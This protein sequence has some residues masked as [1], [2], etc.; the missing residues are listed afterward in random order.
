MGYRAV[1]PLLEPNDLIRILR[2]HGT[3]DCSSL[4]AQEATAK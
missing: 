3:I 4:R 1:Q 2:E